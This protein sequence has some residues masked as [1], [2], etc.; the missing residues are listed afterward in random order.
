MGKIQ[1]HPS[2]TLLQGCNAFALHVQQL[3]GWQGRGCHRIWRRRCCTLHFLPI[4]VARRL[5]GH[6]TE[7]QHRAYWNAPSI[8]CRL[9]PGHTPPQPE[10]NP[11][12][13]CFSSHTAK[14]QSTPASPHPK[15][16]AL[17]YVG[18]GP[19]H[20]LGELA[21]LRTR[22]ERLGR[23]HY[24][25]EVT[26]W[27][28]SSTLHRVS[29]PWLL[30]ILQILV[31]QGTYACGW[32]CRDER[33]V[34]SW[35]FNQPDQDSQSLTASWVRK[36]SVSDWCPRGLSFGSPRLLLT[37]FQISKSHPLTGHQAET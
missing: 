17:L 16:Q 3:C 29:P 22:V 27:R 24:G 32:R 26:R 21:M 8:Q 31:V 2:H 36:T 7:R 12:P 20:D 23:C 1:T 30:T 35:V 9:L 15:P 37:P 33:S 5:K 25:V 18:V 11:G 13:G 14:P 4:A 6:S 10:C 34:S 19:L 28:D